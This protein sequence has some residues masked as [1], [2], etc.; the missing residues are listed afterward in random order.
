MNILLVIDVQND[1][2]PGGS[3]AVPDGDAILPRVNE[4]MA[5]SDLVIATQDWHPADHLSFASQ[6]AEKNPGELATVD[7]I[8]QILWPDHCVQNSFGAQFSDSLDQNQINHVVVKG[9]DR[10]V[11]SY[12]GFFDNARRR[13]TGLE[14]ILRELSVQSIDVVGLATD[15]C[16]KFTVLD[17]L[18][19]GF[20]VRVLTECIR[21]VDLN[22]NDCAKAVEEMSL[23]GAEII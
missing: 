2:L 11:D 3:L 8:E 7:G 15:Y 5:E 17:A 6:H 23:A 21:G 22:E 1:F 16:V 10:N 19:L 9:T 4:L 20:S 12:S 18:D 14:N 13:T